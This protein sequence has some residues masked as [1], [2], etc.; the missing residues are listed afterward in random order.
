M[1]CTREDAANLNRERERVR[2][3]N[4]YFELLFRLSKYVYNNFMYTFFLLCEL[5]SNH[6]RKKGEERKIYLKR[7]FA[8][9]ATENAQKVNL[10]LAELLAA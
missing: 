4:V 3:K 2:Y 1:L 8:A 9:C 5:L 7:L 6:P 10:I